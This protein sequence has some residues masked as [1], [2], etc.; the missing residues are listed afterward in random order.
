MLGNR[1][2]YDKMAAA[3]SMHWWYSTLHG[4]VLKTLQRHFQHKKDIALLDAGC[5]TGWLM[6][7]LKQQGYTNMQGF[8]ISEHAL[9]H[10][11]KRGLM[12]NR[13]G[14]Q[15]VGDFYKPQSVDAIICCDALYFLDFQQQKKTLEHFAAILKPKGLLLL[16]LPALDVFS[17]TH[18]ISV[19][20]KKRYHHSVLQQLL[21]PYLGLS[22]A[23]FRY[24][25]VALSPVIALAR[26]RQRKKMNEGVGSAV[27]DV[28][29][30]AVGVNMLLKAILKIEM[31]LPPVINFGSSLFVAYVKE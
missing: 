20:I 15:Q 31:K 3:E 22:S 23:T 19:G 29:L 17:G 10:C 21:P 7:Y 27:S 6:L 16:N 25:P 12:V 26:A 11:G 24:W 30:P 1:A 14:L 5:G 13:L 8:D 9:E 4:L 2:E 28:N 18:D